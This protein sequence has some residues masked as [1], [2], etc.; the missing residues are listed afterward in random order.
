[1]K[2]LTAV[3][4]FGLSLFLIA[5]CAV[6]MG[7]DFT[8]P[9]DGIGGADGEARLLY[10]TD[11]NLE[12]YVPIPYTGELPVTRVTHR[13]DLEAEVLWKDAGGGLL[14]SLGLFTAGAV[15][16]AEITITPKDGYVFYDENEFV[17]REGRV[18]AQKDGGGASVRIVAVTYKSAQE[19]PN[20]ESI[21]VHIEWPD[22]ED[23]GIRFN[24]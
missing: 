11:Y 14:P 6:S 7:D 17:Y 5:G 4:G 10:I 3:T 12:T 19:R 18:D 21:D 16:Q 8:L 13:G 23:I 9:R 22:T 2:K 20:T 15:Y 24:W 1:M